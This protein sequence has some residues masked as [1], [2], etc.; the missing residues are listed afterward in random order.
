MTPWN[1]TFSLPQSGSSKYQTTQEVKVTFYSV[2]SGDGMG[3]QLRIQSGGYFEDLLNATVTPSRMEAGSGEEGDDL[4]PG[5]DDHP[6]LLKALNVVE[7]RPSV[8]HQIQ[9]EHIRST[10]C[11]FW[12]IRVLKIDFPLKTVSLNAFQTSQ[13]FCIQVTTSFSLMTKQHNLLRKNVNAN[14]SGN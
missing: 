11:S 10:N 9:Q 5:V 8:E 2:Y 3:T 4:A 14:S 12:F 13:N 7:A 1:K 6:Q